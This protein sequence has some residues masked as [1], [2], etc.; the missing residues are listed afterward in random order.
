MEQK[1]SAAAEVQHFNINLLGCLK[2]LN[3]T[4]DGL[5]GQLGRDL[6]TTLIREDGATVRLGG[7]LNIGCLTLVGYNVAAIRFSCNLDRR[8]GLAFIW[9]DCTAIRFSCNLNR[10]RSLAF[11]WY[12]RTAIRFSCNLDRRRSLAF[13]GGD[14]STVRLG[15]DLDRR[16]LALEAPLDSGYHGHGERDG[17]NLANE[18]NREEQSEDGRRREKHCC[19]ELLEG[20]KD[21]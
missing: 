13:V 11:V 19:W 21:G 15:C 18:E 17:G 5:N 1:G 12:D 16:S 10:R 6:R 14:N 2:Q 20:R 4:V 8:G 7:G 9:Y 3:H